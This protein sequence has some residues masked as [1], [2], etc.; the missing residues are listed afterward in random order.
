M[1]YQVKSKFFKFIIITFIFVYCSNLYFFGQIIDT[2][3]A[4]GDIT[5]VRIIGTEPGDGWVAE[6]DIDGLAAGGT[7]NFGLGSNNDPSTA[8]IVFT[9]ISKG[10]DASGNATTFSRTV[11]GTKQLRLPYGG[12]RINGE[13]SGA[14]TDGETIT[15]ATTGA[16]AKVYGTSTVES[17]Q[18]IVTD[19]SGTPDASNTWT[20][21]D[22]S[23]TLAPSEA[24]AA[25]TN[26]ERI[27]GT[28]LTVKVALSDYIYA[29]DDTGD[30]NSGTAPTVAIASG[31]YT[32]GGTP[33]N[34]YSGTVT[35]NSTAPYQK[36]I[37]NWLVANKEIVSGSTFT[38]RVRAGTGDTN[39]GRS[40]AAVKFT[41]TDEHEHTVTQTVAAPTVVEDQGYALPIIAWVGEIDTSALTQGDTLTS[42]FIAYPWVGDNLI[43]TSDGAHT[44]PTPLYAPLQYLNDKINTYGRGAARVSPTGNNDTGQVVS[45]YSYDSNNP[46]A[47][48]ADEFAAINAIKNYHNGLS[49]PAVARNN[50]GGG[51]V[52]H[53]AGNYT[54]LNGTITTGV[55]TLATYLKFEPSAGV[56]RDQVVINHKTAGTAATMFWI[57]NMTITADGSGNVFTGM[58]YFKVS[59]SV[60][61]PVNGNSF[62]YN[63]VASLFGN[64]ITSINILPVATTANLSVSPVIGNTWN[65]SASKYIRAY[66]FVGNK[67]ISPA[68]PL[69]LHVMPIGLTPPAADGAI[70]ADNYMAGSQITVHDTTGDVS[71]IFGV[72]FENGVFETIQGASPYFK[73]AGSTSSADNVYNVILRNLT[74]VGYLT[75]WNY[76][77]SGDPMRLRKYNKMQGVVHSR[78]TTM[79]DITTEGGAA[80]SRRT[81]SWPETF[82]VGHYGNFINTESTGNY[83]PEFIGI[84]SAFNAA[85]PAFVSD[86]SFKG[87]KAGNGDYNPTSASTFLNLIPLGKNGLPYDLEGNPRNN[88]GTGAAGAYEYGDFDNPTV[89]AF[90]IPAYANSL[91][92]SVSSFTAADDVGVTGYKLTENSVAPLAGDDGWGGTATANYVFTTAGSKTLY[93]WV[94][95]ASGKV[96][97]SATD[98]VLIDMDAPASSASPT[99]ALF[100]AAQS[101]TL[102]CNDG[103]GSGCDKI[104][105]T[106][107][108]S[109]P[110][111]GSSQYSSALNISANTTLKFF[112]TD[113]AGN[114]ESAN[115]ESYTFDTT[116]PTITNASSNKANGNYKAGEVIDINL[117]FSEA[118]TSTGAVTVTLET[119]DTDQTCTFTVAASDTGTCNYTVQAGDTSSDLTVKTISGTITDAAG[120]PVINFTPAT[121]LAANKAII[122]DTTAPVLS[123]TTPVATPGTDS[124]PAYVFNSSEAGT[125]IY[126]G[127]CSSATDSAVSG[128]NDINFSSLADAAY[129]N[130]TITVTD[131]AGN[132]STALAV[133]S[134]TIDT[135]APVLSA[136]TSA[137]NNILSV[138]TGENA[139][140]KYSLTAGIAYAGMAGTFTTTGTLAHAKTISGLTA[141]N[142]YTYYVRCADSLG[143]ANLSDYP[144]TLTIPA[145]AAQPSG[146]IPLYILNQMNISKPLSTPENILSPDNTG[147]PSGGSE[148]ENDNQSG[149][150]G[151]NGTGANSAGSE[152]NQ[153]SSQTNQTSAKNLYLD[154]KKREVRLSLSA[155]IK[156]F[157]RGPD[158]KNP[159]DSNAVKIIAYGKDKSVKINRDLNK[160]RKAIGQ[161]QK[162]YGYS[163]KSATAWDIVHVIAYENVNSPAKTTPQPK[164]DLNKE[165]KALKTFT[166]VYGFLPKSSAD[167]KIIHSYA[168]G[169]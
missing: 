145:E 113:L 152:P 51:V 123:E 45:L 25:I 138:N 65:L 169:N 23:L 164:R 8:K 144:L 84:N 100:S 142:S 110:D 126:G 118:V 73:V 99:G 79:T 148:S 77:K 53:D 16:T 122:I 40:V 86:A 124:T 41:V 50:A 134:F 82:G 153:N 70:I 119:G 75:E 62:Y 7:Y 112:S 95:D 149:A 111:T 85:S 48:F 26:D 57:D 20:G 81:G 147:K 143:N 69:S 120:N 133:A 52:Y 83:A 30:G 129:S 68:Q 88:D 136:G 141:G 43:D 35:N 46:P 47:A 63:T 135:T 130:C 28:T 139:T 34:A 80:D 156:I 101:V 61:S 22:S 6:I 32:A 104:Y 161:F 166:K 121:N 10:Y 33:T 74:I 71:G 140:C 17:A 127:S 162:I 72:L 154:L 160:E 24:P 9:V 37:A 93:A 15:Q 38:L 163:P 146:A 2:K 18:L 92:V 39:Q 158:L 42:N 27:T 117:T 56:T 3:A 97:S 89:T 116:A 132:V 19:V 59:N 150:L 60:I 67:V 125:I 109:E 4:A 13:L 159:K 137:G 167:W 107:N 105:Y 94:K 76:N 168:Y 151:Q 49:A 108:G 87:T 91:T 102:N 54:F 64:T 165:R 115:T 155:F 31:F 55:G 14:F 44:Q 90:T 58:T 78:V 96:S 21:A 1:L 157:G 36:V 103:A 5:A 131:A 11:Y 106:T 66:T 128:S 29:K 98:A 114:S 12:K